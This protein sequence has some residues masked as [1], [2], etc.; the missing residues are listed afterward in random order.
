MSGQILL[1]RVQ[2]S[3]QSVKPLVCILSGSIGPL[4]C[5]ELKMFSLRLAFNLKK[6]GLKYIQ[7][8]PVDE[9]KK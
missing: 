2:L 6:K 1:S 4:I 8:T 3:T 7:G 9:L 5:T